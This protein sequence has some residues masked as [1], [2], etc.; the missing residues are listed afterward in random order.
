MKKYCFIFTILIIFSNQIF[1]QNYFQEY[2]ISVSIGSNGT[3]TRLQ[4]TTYDSLLQTTVTY[5]T[6]W[7][8]ESHVISSNNFGKL[9]YTLWTSGVTQFPSVGFIIYDYN[10]HQFVDEQVQ[11]PTGTDIGVNVV[12]GRIWVSVVEHHDN[13]GWIWAIVKYYRYDLYEHQ[14]YWFF[15][16]ELLP[17]LSWYYTPSGNTDFVYDAE[18]YNEF[19]FMDPIKNNV[20]NQNVNNSITVFK[21]DYAYGYKDNKPDQY[22]YFTYDPVK[23]EYCKYPRENLTKGATRG[24]Y[25]AKDTT[26]LSK[27]FFFIYDQ[28]VQDWVTDSVYSPFITSTTAKEGVVAYFD[29]IPGVAKKVHCL[30]YNPLLHQWVRDS[31]AVNGVASVLTIENGTVKWNDAN[32]TNIR[33]YDQVTG[34]GNY[35]T[36]LLMHFAL[37]DY[38]SEGAPVIFVRNYSIGTENIYYDF[39]D[40]IQSMDNRHVLWHSYKN[41]GTYNICIVDSATGQ[42]SCQPFTFNIC[43]NAGTAM[44]S[45]S[46]RCEGDSVEL[47][48]SSFNGNIQWQR[49]YGNNWIDEILPGATA[50]QY[51]V[52]PDTIAEYRAKVQLPGCIP[53]V[54]NSLKVK[55]EKQLSSYFISD[56]LIEQ[57]T[58]NSYR[59]YVIGSNASQ[60]TWQ[61]DVGT[62]WYNFSATTNSLLISGDGLYRAILTSGVCFAD[63]TDT[64][65]VNEIPFPASPTTVPDFSCGPDTVNLSV[66]SVGV[67]HWF[68]SSSSTSFLHMGNSFSPFVSS[69]TTFIVKVSDGVVTEAG[70]PDTTI[71]TTLNYNGTDVKG[72]R[73]MSLTP[74]TLATIDVFG[75]DSCTLY[76]SLVH[77]TTKISTTSRSL[78]IAPGLNRIPL[79]FS[80]PGNVSYDLMISATAPL[81]ANISGFN[82]PMNIPGS[83]VTIT[84]YVDSTFHST[85]DFINIYN[86]KFSTGCLSNNSNCTATVYPAIFTPAIIPFGGVPWF[87][88]GDSLYLIG[89]PVGNYSYLWYKNGI[90]TG[91]TGANY[92]V[93]LPGNYS[94]LVSSANCS[95]T[96]PLKRIT[97]PCIQPLNP[98]DK[99]ENLTFDGDEFSVS[100][101][102]NNNGNLELDSKSDMQKQITVSIV[103]ITGKQLF[104]SQL[105]LEE[106]I[107]STQIST[108]NLAS[109]IYIIMMDGGNKTIITKAV[110]SW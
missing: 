108:T 14:W 10:L 83:P 66:S 8:S 95:A 30:V 16:E 48:L 84:G 18:L 53:N 46:I 2:P 36:T 41:S 98:Q 47:S 75:T 87:C 49:K 62:S 92:S 51:F 71:G 26:D 50:Q 85:P 93:K 80:L 3:Q 55:F 35:N 19:H 23:A 64:I 90:S 20:I 4:C 99:T 43:G 52:S 102:F 82:Y 15:V 74:V 91:H 13:D 42:N 67:A 38:I 5:N 72:I 110:K 1:G 81:I 70:V 17:S 94:L 24:I 37:E 68:A 101:F 106:G 78:I 63:T 109:G 6:P 58:N 33:G 25:Y 39:G 31:I 56:S 100:A 28:G 21:D 57:C 86:M 40:G 61:K 22:Y 69:T 59:V 29:S 73:L 34:W 9:G 44:A 65:T 77:S 89:Q 103:D 107:S 79:S 45:D 104:N 60:Y 7:R 32:G 27:H 105:V 76:I 11:I 96:S 97:V 54:S 12:C 88:K